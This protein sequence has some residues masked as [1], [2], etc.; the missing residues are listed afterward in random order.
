MKKIEFN[1]KIVLFKN[2][3]K[4]KI[5]NKF[6]TFKKANSVYLELIDKSNNVIFNKEF[7]N[8]VIS[9]YEIAILKIH[10][11]N[12]ETIYK[13]DDLGRQ[14]KVLLDD[15]KYDIIKILKYNLP[16]KILDLSNNKKISCEDFIKNYLPK[17]SISMV[18]SINNKIVVQNDDKINLFTLKTISDSNRFIDSIFNYFLTQKRSDTLFIK[19]VSVVQRKYL[20]KLLEENGFS[21]SYLQR[22]STTHPS[23]K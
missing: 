13:K 19:D 21:K 18:S 11:Q 1:Y 7:E 5:I 12:S 16:D 6:Q 17:D 3:I 2:K 20:Y 22:H 23:K 15:E 8:G 4:K 14:S 9:E 10:S